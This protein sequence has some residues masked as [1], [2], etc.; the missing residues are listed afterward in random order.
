M[1]LATTL[2]ATCT[3]FECGQASFPAPT[4]LKRIAEVSQ[5]LCRQ[6]FLRP[7]DPDEQSMLY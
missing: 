2:F 3:Q 5:L 4:V 7:G 6:Q 1:G